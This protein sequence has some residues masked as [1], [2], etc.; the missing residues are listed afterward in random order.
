MRLAGPE[1]GYAGQ[2]LQGA[3]DADS[4]PPAPDLEHDGDGNPLSDQEK[5]L[6]ELGVKT[7]SYR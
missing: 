1:L 6:L 2:G 5:Q 3:G 7:R 4:A